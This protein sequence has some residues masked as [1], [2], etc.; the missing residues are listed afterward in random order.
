MRD[1]HV[2]ITV[3]LVFLLALVLLFFLRS[4]VVNIIVTPLLYLFWV[5][6][7]ILKS[8]DQ[9]YI[10]WFLLGVMVIIM[11][12]GLLQQQRQGQTS[13]R[14]LYRQRQT[15]RVS[16]WSA[17][18][19][20]MA[21]GIYP[22][23]YSNYELRKLILSVLGYRVNLSPREIEERLKNDKFE[24]PPDIL[25]GFQPKNQKSVGEKKPI[26]SR[27]LQRFNVISARESKA[28]AAKVSQEVEE[29]IQY[30]EKQLEINREH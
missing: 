15:Q 24:V 30:L 25:S 1:R 26:P 9:R 7:L 23:E 17:Q 14:P 13:S 2:L 6:D 22:E 12:R 16:F 27:L 4:T 5:M 8:I 29:V 3:L 19:H 28:N 20:R 18:L 10:W 11:L 21:T